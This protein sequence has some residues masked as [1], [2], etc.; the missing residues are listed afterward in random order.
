MNVEIV[1]VKPLDKQTISM[2]LGDEE[3]EDIM[4]FDVECKVDET[5]HNYYISVESEEVE[6]DFL[7]NLD[8]FY[9][10]EKEQ[11]DNELFQ[12]VLQKFGEMIKS[13]IEEGLKSIEEDEND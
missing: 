6:N 7:L 2:L 8:L 1:N 4:I 3:K 13:S 12:I 11:P 10:F 9:D 5:L